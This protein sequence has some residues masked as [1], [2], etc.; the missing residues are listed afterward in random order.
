MK[1]PSWQLPAGVDRGTWDYIES[2]SIADQYE[3]FLDSHA[4]FQL[5]T[6]IV[7]E[8]IAELTRIHRSRPLVAADLGC[9]T[10]RIARRFG[11]QLPSDTATD[12]Q[13]AETRWINIDLSQ[14]M[15]CESQNLRPSA[16]DGVF[17][18]RGNLSELAFLRDESLHLCVCLFSS[19][20]MVR[21]RANRRQ[22]LSGVSRALRPGGRLL[23]HVHNRYHSL[24]EPGGIR[25]LLTSYANS[26]RRGQEFGDRVYPYRGLPA[27]FL[28]IYSRGELLRDLGSAGFRKVDILSV[29]SD[30]SALL[31]RRPFNRIRSGGFMAVAQM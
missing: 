15:L 12:D 22:L 11:A 2:T 29:S 14:P 25:W 3:E 24:F 6:S 5:D 21:G 1:R 17:E 30:G 16:S 4:L 8:Q 20:G 19:I 28:H 13:L 10:G 18:V 7:Q 23:V 9:G 31:P 27:M 26:F